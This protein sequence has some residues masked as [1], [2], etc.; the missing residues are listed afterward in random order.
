MLKLPTQYCTGEFYFKKLYI[1]VGK[2]PN[3]I[4][5]IEHKLPEISER[6][7]TPAI[8]ASYQSE[9]VLPS[10]NKVNHYWGKQPLLLLEVWLDL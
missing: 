4:P 2:L 10:A 6:I 1:K 8:S 3:E 5:A 9:Y 7:K